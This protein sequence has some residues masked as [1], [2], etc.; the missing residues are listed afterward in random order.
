MQRAPVS[1]R[2]SAASGEAATRR[3]APFILI[4]HDTLEYRMRAALQ[5][6][7]RDGHAASKPR[8]IRIERLD[9][10]RIGNSTTIGSEEATMLSRTLTIEIARVTEAAAIAAARLRGRGDEKDGRPGGGRCHAQALN[11]HRHG[12]HRG[13]RRGRARRG[14]DALYRREGR[15]RHGASDRYRARSAGRHDAHRQGH[16]ECRSRWSRWP[17]AAACCMRPT[18]TW[19]R[20][21]SV[22]GYPDGVVD[23]DV[24]PEREYPSAGQG[25]GLSRHRDITACILDR[26]RHADI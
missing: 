24:S 5:Q 20:S 7:E 2:A 1:D 22:G 6:I 10:R 26:P 16:A 12:R 3:T 25:Q 23:L 4:T 8:M 9:P 17:R 11:S 15:H 14:A 13:D 21:P 19:T 18:A